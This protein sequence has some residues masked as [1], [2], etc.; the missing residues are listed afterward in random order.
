MTT[1]DLW[2]CNVYTE[3]RRVQNY[4]RDP[5]MS[6]H[7]QV[8]IILCVNFISLWFY[9]LECMTIPDRLSHHN[10]PQP[11][12]K[13]SISWR[14]C[15]PRKATMLAFFICP[16][17]LMKVWPCWLAI[18]MNCLTGWRVSSAI[19]ICN[20]MLQLSSDCEIHP[21]CIDCV[22]GEVEHFHNVHID[23]FLCIYDMNPNKDQWVM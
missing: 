23:F 1:T 15:R 8:I 22:Y 21:H 12:E 7:P 16:F 4:C 3:Y 18:I 6:H 20:V 13:Y 11:R 2:L 9:F 19:L 10:F 17:S 14:P 5:V